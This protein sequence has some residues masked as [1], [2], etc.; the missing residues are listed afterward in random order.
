[1]KPS[2]ALAYLPFATT[3]AE[4]LVEALH[5]R[6]LPDDVSPHEAR[7]LGAN[8]TARVRRAQALARGN[9]PR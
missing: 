7:I 6:H 3:L 9:A 4:L 2:S 8:A 5:L 1:M